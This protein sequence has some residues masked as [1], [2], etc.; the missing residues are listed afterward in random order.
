M[1]T[2]LKK[3][4]KPNIDYS[5][6]IITIPNILSFFRLLLIPIIA[7]LYIKKQD[8]YMTVIVLGLS[9][10]TDVVDGIIARKFNMISD[11]GKAFDPIADKLTQIIVL[12]CLV[13]RFDFMIIPLIL[14]IIKELFAGITGLLTIKKTHQVHSAVWHGK[15][16]TVCLYIL[17]TVHIIWY[18]IPAHISN[19]LILLCTVMMLLSATL[20]GI[21]N[22]K[23]ICA[24]ISN[25][26]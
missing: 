14:L 17:M 12:F 23:L 22:I 26:T 9:G 8:Y 25:D 19:I 20:Y 16:T 1:D 10:L 3:D 15:A 7:W 2:K 6:R 5:K 24:A 13:S 18:T 11:F 4:S 21:K